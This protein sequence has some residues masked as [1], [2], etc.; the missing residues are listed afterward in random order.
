[1]KY[2]GSK[3]WM[4]KNGLGDVLVKQLKGARR[5]VDLFAGSG[6]VAC[7]VAERFPVPVIASDLQA[8]SAVLTGAVICRE[9]KMDYKPIWDEWLHQA[10]QRCRRHHRIPRPR[11]WTQAGINEIRIWATLQIQLPI[12][13]A[14]GGH[15]FS[16]AQAVWIDALRLTLP[17]GEPER[18]V[19]LAALVQSASQCVA[20]PGHTAQPFQ[21]TPTAIGYLQKAWERDIT[22]HTAIVFSSLAARH[23]KRTGEVLVADANEAAK[24]LRTSDIAFIDP[25]YSGVQYSRFY[26]VLETIALGSCGE[27]TGAGRYPAA[28]SRPRSRY[29]MKTESQ[30]ALSELLK[31][32][33]S[34]GSRAIL[35]FPSH[36]CSNGLSGDSV[37]TTAS[38]Y[39]YVN[40]QQIERKF[41]TLGGKGDGHKN[42]A[43]RAARLHASELILVLDPR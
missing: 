20:S 25:P 4:L 35:T 11:G 36:S 9:H 39:F 32:V 14:Y 41:S 19:A 10:E 21:P 23:A 33:A 3:Q 38:S 28:E 30:K 37:R 43:G 22:A 12:T 34:R 7:H 26:H 16:P 18:T 1:M 6:A 24:K 27:V 8:Y 2:M 5:F 13:M 29:S 42:E 31:T 17:N 15:Y 40:E